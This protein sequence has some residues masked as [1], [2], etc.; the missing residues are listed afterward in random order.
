[1][2]H[3]ILSKT[4]RALVAYLISVGA[5]DA[6]TIVPA[7]RSLEKPLPVAIVFSA[8]ARL[9]SAGV[10]EVNCSVMVKSSASIDVDDDDTAPKAASETLIGAV[11]DALEAG[12]D[13]HEQGHQLADAI[14]AAARASQN[15]EDADLAQFTVQDIKNLGPEAG[16]DRNG[17]AW[18]DTINLELVACPK[19]VS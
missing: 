2:S 8:R 10:Y 14:T 12:I 5:G 4:D 19:D 17:P 13:A 3:K 6:A 18:V 15:P 1:M 11:A 9:I 16:I 7:K